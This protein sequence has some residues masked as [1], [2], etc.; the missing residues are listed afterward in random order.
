MKEIE[1]GN[2]KEEIL[3]FQ[4]VLA[5][6]K[7]TFSELAK[8]SPKHRDTREHLIEIVKVII[9]EEEMMEELFRKKKLPLKHIEPR[10]RVSPKRW[11]GIENISLQCVLSLQTTI[12]TF[13]I[14]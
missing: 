11:S 13:L 1:N 4:S 7:I 3:H 10:V 12:H 6:F 5:D 9:K 14:I 2:R 8:E